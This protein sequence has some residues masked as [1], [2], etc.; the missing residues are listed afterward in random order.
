MVSSESSYKSSRC[1]FYV[2]KALA[3]QNDPITR[4][5]QRNGRA[6]GRV[7]GVICVHDARGYGVGQGCESGHA[8]SFS[9]VYR[10]IVEYFE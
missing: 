9:M 5:N 10:R 3:G 1:F 6:V 8:N 7:K 4:L 2:K